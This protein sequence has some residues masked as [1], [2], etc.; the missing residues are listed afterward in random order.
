MT[1]AN[2]VFR[3]RKEGRLAAALVL[4]REL[5]DEQDGDVWVTRALGWCLHDSLKIAEQ[6]GGVAEIAE[7]IDEFDGLVIADDDVALHGARNNWRAR[8]PRK[9]GGPSL[10]T[11]I[12]QAKA[13]SDAGQRQQSL[14]LWRSAVAYFPDAPQAAQGLGWELARTIKDVAA[15]DP[16]LD[17]LVREYLGEYFRLKHVDR[18]SALHS[19]ML[20]RAADAVE[21]FPNFLRFLRWWDLTN[22]RPEDF[23]RYVPDGSDR[24]FD[25]LVERLLKAIH[26][27]AQAESDVE[28]LQWAADFFERTYC[29][30]PQQEW[31]EY[32]YARLLLR[33]G[34]RK[35]AH[36]LIIPIVRRKRGEFWAW[37]AFA[38][39]FDTDA[40]WE[41][42][43]CLCRALL[44]RSQRESFL[45]NVHIKLA[46]L[47]IEFGQYSEARFEV[48]RAAF[49]RE[50]EGWTQSPNLAKWQQSDWY[51]AAPSRASNRALY[52]A[53]ATEADALLFAGLPVIDGV[54]VHHVAP[55]EGKPGPTFIGFN[56]NGALLETAAWGDYG[57]ALNTLE[58]GQ[59]ITL[60]LDESGE[61]PLVVSV[62]LRTGSTWD[63]VPDRIGVVRHVNVERG[64]T[65]VVLSPRESCAVR[66][67]RFPGITEIRPGTAVAVKFRL[68]QKRS[69]IMPLACSRT[70]LVPSTRFCVDASGPLE[71][72]Q[73]GRFGFVEADHRVYVPGEL[74][75]GAGLQSGMSV[76]VR[77]VLDLDRKTGKP[78]WRA[79]TARPRQR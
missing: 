47:L 33:T 6:T 40:H 68:D 39:T 57:I 71:V 27:A 64:H 12:Q 9:D 76:T 2:A 4:A 41:R 73:D 16:P 24:S 58:L 51:S 30:F 28:L 36:D 66:H 69:M 43:A 54:V 42:R 75:Q 63:V 59:P 29:Q 17:G 52:E 8:M 20:R 18:P 34:N 49:L 70:T 26:K 32:Y 19:I 13:C 77:A 61:R 72:C 38:D 7:L 62:K 14:K 10:H 3:L 78:G 31:F 50:S 15:I 35:R 25:S 65:V 21:Q 5:Y 44:C 55:R 48:S 23:Q 56:R 60:Q 45:V 67:D 11:L 22:L 74:I 79:L 53:H 37:T 46:E 1:D